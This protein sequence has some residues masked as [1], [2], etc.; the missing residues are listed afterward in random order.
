[1]RGPWDAKPGDSVRVTFN[2]SHADIAAFLEDIKVHGRPPFP[3]A[4]PLFQLLDDG[5][6]FVNSEAASAFRTW[7][8]TLPGYAD[9]ASQS[10]ALLFQDTAR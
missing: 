8:S 4:F 7:A 10:P 1:V 5:E 9:S 3:P 6:V 2:R